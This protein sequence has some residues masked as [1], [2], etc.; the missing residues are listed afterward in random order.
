MGFEEKLKEID[1][2][3]NLV[4]EH[5]AGMDKA[6]FLSSIGTIMKIYS[7]ENDIPMKDFMIEFVT[8]IFAAEDAFPGLF[9][10]DDDDK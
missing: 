5:T 9:D 10:D 6:S 2:L 3:I 1:N 8:G 4:K 7:L